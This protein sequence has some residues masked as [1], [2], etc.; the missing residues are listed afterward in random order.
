MKKSFNIIFLL[1]AI[2][3]AGVGA[4]FIFKPFLI[5]IFLGF[6]LSQLFRGWYEKINKFM[7]NRK[8][9]ASITACVTVLMVI[10]IPLAL[11]ISLLAAETNALYQS[12]QK[13]N[14]YLGFQIQ[15]QS[16]LLEN[17]GF[18][19]GRV[20][21]DSLLNQ[22]TISSESAK[23]ISNFFFNV[24]KKAYQG[25]SHLIFITFVTFFVLYYLFK[26]GDRMMKKLMNLSPL[27]N[28]QEKILL[29]NFLEISKATLKG[30][31]VI[32]LV[33]GALTS[34]L[35]WITG[36]SS[37][38]IWGL[39][40]AIFS[41]IPLL[42]PVLVWVPAGIIMLFS[43]NIWQAIV[44][45]AVGALLISTIDNFLRPK[46]VGDASSLHPLLVF[47]STIGGIIVFG[48][49]GFLIGP[50]IIVLLLSLLKIYEIEFR[51]ELKEIN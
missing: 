41:I 1:S 45:F 4:Y 47:L 2:L 33:Q 35:F 49:L 12:Y 8:S 21:L 42:G 14:H 40:T 11:I 48:T 13:G 24:L 19:E 34:L 17:F 46:L 23:S 25:T 37:P 31:L 9:L 3:L 39:V 32:A 6:I 10:I 5:A 15:S 29:S 22:G 16:A 26:D 30:S 28:H 36:V 20:D 38:V 51:K 50:I 7:G 18:K 43:G 27:P 44:I